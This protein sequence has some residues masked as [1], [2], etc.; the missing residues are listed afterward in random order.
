MKW[1]EKWGQPPKIRP[2]PAC[3]AYTLVALEWSSGFQANRTFPLVCL[4]PSLFCV[5]MCKQYGGEWAW[6]NTR[7]R[8]I[9]Y[10]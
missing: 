4:H 1:T 9:T 3:I 7:L 8:L 5:C 2:W 10:E 6:K